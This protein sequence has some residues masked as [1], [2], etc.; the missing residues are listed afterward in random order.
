[1]SFKDLSLR[2]SYSSDDTDVLYDFYIPCLNEAVLYRRLAA[3]YSS[4]SLSV[5]ANGIIGLLKNNGHMQLVIGPQ[6]SKEDLI[7]VKEAV[8][9]PEVFIGDKIIRDLESIEDDAVLEHSRA[10][11]WMLAHDKLELK[12]AVKDSGIFHLKLGVF[13]DAKGNMLSF[14]G[15]ANE[16]ASGWRENDEYIKVAI[17]W[18]ESSKNSFN[19]DVKEFYR[20]WENQA[21]KTDVVSAPEAVKDRL[22]KLAP[23]IFCIQDLEAIYKAHLQQEDGKTEK[24]RQDEPGTTHNKE[25][26]PIVVLRD[27]QN[28][29]IEAWQNN[30]M[31]GMFE[32]ATGSGKT[33]TAL[34]CVEQA[35]IAAKK[36]RKNCI[37]I[38]SSP[39]NDIGDQW[40]KSLLDFGIQGK[41]IRCD[42]NNKVWRAELTDN[43]KMLRNLNDKILSVVT[44]HTT[45][46]MPDFR[47]II[48]MNQ[49]PDNICMLIGDEMHNLGAKTLSEGLLNMYKLRLGLSASPRRWFDDTGTELIYKY[50]GDTVYELTLKDAI[51]RKFLVKYRYHPHF[52][53]L[54]EDELQDY[55]DISERISKVFNQSKTEEEKKELLDRLYF[56][57]SEIVKRAENKFDVLEEIIST[58]MPL[59]RCLIYLDRLED[60][61]RVTDIL[62]DLPIISARYSG[63]ESRKERQDILTGFQQENI[64][65]LVAVKCLDEGIDL[66]NA[67]L[68]IICASSTNPAQ[69]IQRRG[70]LLRRFENKDH[71]TIIDMILQP[72][73]D[74]VD[75]FLRDTELRIFDK[76][77]VRLKEFAESAMNKGECLI[78]LSKRVRLFMPRG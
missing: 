36:D 24:T 60:I 14:S 57:R 12:F 30:D 61:D 72:P 38:I 71:A 53:S 8:V 69:Y 29:A 54:T 51:E 3:Y 28:E 75:D 70:R 58:Y 7:A 32:M 35:I 16:S 2:E 37:V 10:L 40:A 33:Y 6:L 26:K 59:K 23:R 1:M 49:S 17:G 76:E 9:E 31:Q 52:F 18:Q 11:G 67:S 66:P 46:S 65:V 77:V 78:E 68:G 56:A 42:G 43:L 50:F 20:Y 27:Y 48:S 5:A 25:E 73:V 44:T 41:I 64:N 47:D 19:D 63:H 13:N 74:T 62:Q 15:S 45:L 34:G 22:I 4:S 39:R 21:L 55:I